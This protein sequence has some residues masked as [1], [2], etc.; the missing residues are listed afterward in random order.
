MKRGDRVA[1]VGFWGGYVG[2]VRA[3]DTDEDGNETVRVVFDDVDVVR[4]VRA[5]Q[6]K[7]INER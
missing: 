6:V 2:T 5:S 1:G 4:T 3:M 7:I